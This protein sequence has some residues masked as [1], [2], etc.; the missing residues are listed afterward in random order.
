MKP[1]VHS[2]WES[3]DDEIARI[4][5]AKTPG[6]RIRMT[7]DGWGVARRMLQAQ[8]RRMHPEWTAVQVEQEV[9]RRMIS[10]ST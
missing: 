7:T 3:V 8:V 10:G 5:A 4:L 9:C 6:E 2:A 1:S